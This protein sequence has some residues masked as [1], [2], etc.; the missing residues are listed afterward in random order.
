MNAVLATVITLVIVALILWAVFK[1][2]PIVI[3][4]ENPVPEDEGLDEVST[5]K[6]SLP[7]LFKEHGTRSL[8]GLMG[9]FEFELHK[10]LYVYDDSLWEN[11]QIYDNGGGATPRWTVLL[12]FEKDSEG[13][14]FHPYI[15][16][17]DSL[18]GNGWNG[19]S[20]YPMDYRTLYGKKV[21][22]ADLPWEVKIFICEAT[23]TPLITEYELPEE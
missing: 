2:G 19:G 9:I 3:L 6:S 13:K 5:L 15:Q 21:R 12:P 22:F 14:R 4:H 8:K 10:R 18:D 16:F 1:F 20:V 11:Y 23:D 17:D 7:E